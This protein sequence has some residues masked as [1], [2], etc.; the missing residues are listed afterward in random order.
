MATS[1][2]NGMV[3]MGVIVG[4]LRKGSNTKKIALAMTKLAPSNMKFDFVEI[5]QLPFYDEDLETKTPPQAWVDFRSNIKSFDAILFATPEYNRS[6]PGVLK[7]ALD[8]GSRPYGSG[9]WDAKPCAV[10]STSVGALGGF[11][12]HHHLRQCIGCM[13]MPVMPGPEA[14]IG[15]SAALI[16]EQGEVTVETTSLFLKTFM[17]KFERWIKVNRGPK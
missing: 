7:N 10:I 16:N 4:S 11:G 2:N 12:A 15:G 9:V 1:G 8:V 6:V 3:T 17:E 13:N 5:G 14:Y